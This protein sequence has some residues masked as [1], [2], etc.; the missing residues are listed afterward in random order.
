MCASSQEQGA[1]SLTSSYVWPPPWAKPKTTEQAS[2][3][4]QENPELQAQAFTTAA[5]SDPKSGQA[6]G[7]AEGDPA[8]SLLRLVNPG[9]GSA[10]LDV[11]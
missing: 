3:S 2:R 8:T 1:S 7:L 5:Y 4:W 9:P 10:L 6:Q 11:T